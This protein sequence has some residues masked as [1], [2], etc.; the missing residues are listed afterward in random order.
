MKVTN[1]VSYARDMRWYGSE[2]DRIMKL[3]WVTLLLLLH[4]Q[5]AMWL[6]M[7]T[8]LN[9]TSKSSLETLSPFFY[10]Q[11]PVISERVGKWIN[12][13]V[14]LP[15]ESIKTGSELFP[16]RSSHVP[17]WPANNVLIYLGFWTI[18]R[19][20]VCVIVNSKLILWPMTRLSRHSRP[21]LTLDEK[22]FSRCQISLPSSPTLKRAHTHHTEHT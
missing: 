16:F 15:S 4:N 10:Y 2:L 19:C 3:Y 11:Q 5:A 1:D 12:K 13:V 8:E 17:G 7:W 18:L 9:S 20:D 6:E 22:L 14:H 21:R